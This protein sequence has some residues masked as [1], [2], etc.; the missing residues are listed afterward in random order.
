MGGGP[1]GFPGLISQLM[2]FDGALDGNDVYKVWTAGGG[3]AGQQMPQ[4]PMTGQGELT[5]DD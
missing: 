1:R 2:I 3:E 4:D 5:E